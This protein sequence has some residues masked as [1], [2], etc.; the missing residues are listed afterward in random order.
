[1]TRITGL[2]G[3]SVALG[4]AAAGI[5]AGQEGPP[6]PT[7][8]APVAATLGVPRPAA[9]LGVPAGYVVRAAPEGLPMPSR[10]PD[11]A[12]PSAFGTGAAGPAV[13]SF[14]DPTP[15]DSDADA[16]SPV[17]F[18]APPAAPRFWT[19]AEY[20][21]WRT[22]GEHLPPLVTT[23]GPG[24]LG[25]L[26]DPQTATV[27]GNNSQFA[28]A[29]SGLRLR[30]GLWLDD[31]QT[32]GFDVGGFW[33]NTSSRRVAVG[34]DGSAVGV[35]RPFFNVGLA[36]QDV[37]LVGFQQDVGGGVLAPILAGSTTVQSSTSLWG[38]DPNLRLRW[39]TGCNSQLDVFAGYRYVRLRDAVSVTED[40]TATDPTEAGAPLGTPIGV[41]DRFQSTN[42]FSG[43]QLGL[44][45]ETR[46]G[47]WS[48]AGRAS[49]VLG[50]TSSRT[51][52]TG[53]TRV[54][55]PDGSAS[56]VSPGGLLALPTNMGTH[57]T[58]RFGVVPE[59][60][61]TLGYNVTDRLRLTAGYTLLYWNDVARAGD[62]IDLGVNGSFV[63]RVGGTT[64]TGDARPAFPN[65]HTDYWRRG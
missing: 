45:G 14:A 28:G 17:V 34:S 60:S 36:A 47:R 19:T 6:R 35:F 64:P 30:A 61:L 33:L 41:L 58:S 11:S 42:T 25:T 57:P 26:G 20:L 10:L 50:V 63:P 3:V 44:A 15:W 29:R 2:C 56:A 52:I 38:F 1:M 8:G 51:T 40:L 18:P 65:R 9:R 4:L 32:C 37:E 62:Q 48:L 49:A 39:K 27:V 55:T 24:L 23:A 5:S 16:G 13:T 7:L 54:T 59:A 31:C 22:R 21:T 43:G 46:F 53:A 12:P